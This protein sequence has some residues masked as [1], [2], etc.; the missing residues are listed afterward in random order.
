MLGNEICRSCASC[1]TP[2]HMPL[3]R[4]DMARIVAAGF[5]IDA[6]SEPSSEHPGLRA[7]KNKGGRC[8]FLEGTGPFK[9]RLYPHHPRGCQFFPLIY[10]VDKGRCVLDK[11]Y[12]PHWRL[13]TG[14]HAR[15]KAE[16]D[17]L[18]GY[19]KAELHLI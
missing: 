12:C 16:C 5:S 7:L 8:F 19:L 14:E 11:K 13:F 1:C 3:S 9:C 15:M 10:D 18:V 6:C 4:D 2:T 17:A